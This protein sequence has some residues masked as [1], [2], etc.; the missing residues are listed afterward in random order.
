MNTENSLT[1]YSGGISS[2]KTAALVR[3]AAENN[4]VIV[5]TSILR[6]TELL[7]VAQSFGVFIPRPITYGAFTVRTNHPVVRHDVVKYAI[8]DITRYLAHTLPNVEALTFDESS[9]TAVNVSGQALRTWVV[10][11]RHTLGRRNNRKEEQ[12]FPEFL[13]TLGARV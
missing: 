2:G 8:E 7:H 1:I 11:L 12:S 5:C 10:H 13:E 3:H 4:L 9:V 6:V